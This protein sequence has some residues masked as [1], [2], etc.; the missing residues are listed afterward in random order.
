MFIAV[1]F[2]ITNKWKQAKYPSIDEWIKM[3]CIYTMEYYPAIKNKN[4]TK[5]NLTICNNMDRTSGYY[6]K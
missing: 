5:Q 3:W 2:T 6:A 1:L 4:K